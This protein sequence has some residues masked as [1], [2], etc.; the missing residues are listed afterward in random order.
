MFAGSVDQVLVRDFFPVWSPRMQKDGIFRNAISA[1][2]NQTEL[3]IVVELEKTHFYKELTA[4]FMIEV[5]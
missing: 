5:A 3:T 4:I 2:L 1:S